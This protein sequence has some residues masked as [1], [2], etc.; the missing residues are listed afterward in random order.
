[1]I[2]AMELDGKPAEE[3]AREWI[4]ANEAVWSAWLP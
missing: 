2:A 3:A 1:M 4:D